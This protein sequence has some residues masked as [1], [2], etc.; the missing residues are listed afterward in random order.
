VGGV[1][2]RVDDAERLARAAL[3]RVL[4]PG[5]VPAHA[6]VAEHGAPAVWAALRGDGPVFGA[7][8]RLVAGA[9]H[10]AQGYDPRRDLE[11]LDRLGA[12]LVCPGDEEWPADRLTWPS[13]LLDDAPPL[14]LHVR[15]PGR[16]DEVVDR[17]VAVVGARASSAYGSLVS[18][19]LAFALA[20][21]G[22]T[23]VSGAAY[24]VDGAAHTGAL[25]SGAAPTVAVLAC[26]LDRAYPAGHRD[27]LERIAR[28]GLVISEVPVGSAPTRSRFLVRNRLIAAL[29]LGTVAVEAA[30]RSGSLATIE[31]AG[32]LGRRTM[33]VPG[34]V[35]SAMSAGTNQLLRDGHTCVTGAADVVA[36]VGG[37]DAGAEQVP[38]GE[39]RVRDDLPASVRQ[40]LDAV[41]LR[42]GAGPASIAR[43]AGVS[44]LVVQQVL[45][46]LVLHGLVEQTAE[47][48]RLTPLGAGGPVPAAR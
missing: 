28:T 38:V 17:S 9:R 37:M 3:A 26:G 48:F 44:P 5:A 8:A 18:R 1:T 7:S 25:T 36:H 46:P 24:G 20:E 12:R 39:Q 4:E 27:L 15:G 6:L 22:W 34:P 45:P 32:K 30:A 35:T 31:R 13:E 41:P 16:L 21:R 2:A 33:A 11:A 43:A 40:V 14:A 19:E 42:R 23:V 47:G 10:R 29:S